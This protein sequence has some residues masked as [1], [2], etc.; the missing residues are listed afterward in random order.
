M[1][2]L[3][4]TLG[5]VERMNDTGVTL[6]DIAEVVAE[7]KDNKDGKPLLGFQILNS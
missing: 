3:A 4:S 7:L 6:G 2:W 1:R 5:E